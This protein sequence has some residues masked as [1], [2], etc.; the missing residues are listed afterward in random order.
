MRYSIIGPTVRL[1]ALCSML[2]ATWSCRYAGPFAAGRSE[3]REGTLPDRVARFLGQGGG[4][5]PLEL[6]LPSDATDSAAV[7]LVV[8]DQRAIGIENAKVAILPHAM[9]M[10]NY[11]KD[12]WQPVDAHGVYAKRLVPGEY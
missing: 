3:I 6:I 11:P 8:V 12:G 5:L 7:Y 10:P 1:L 2:G 4:A 9:S